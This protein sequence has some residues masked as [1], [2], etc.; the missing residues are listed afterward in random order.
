MGHY[1]KGFNS[2][3][4]PPPITDDDRVGDEGDG[5]HIGSTGDV[6]REARTTCPAKQLRPITISNQ[7][8]VEPATPTELSVKGGEIKYNVVV[9]RHSDGVNVVD[10]VAVGLRVVLR[11]KHAIGAG[12]IG[13][14]YWTRATTARQESPEEESGQS[15]HLQNILNVHWT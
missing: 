15:S 2:P 10:V 9:F 8:V 4:H 11:L 6:W 5:D 3:D 13:C 12:D 1:E 7:D 14:C